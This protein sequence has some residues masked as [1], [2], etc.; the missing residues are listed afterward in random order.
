MEKQGGGRSLK[1]NYWKTNKTK[2]SKSA[3]MY[4]QKNDVKNFTL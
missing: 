2:E 4:V 1:P 3:I